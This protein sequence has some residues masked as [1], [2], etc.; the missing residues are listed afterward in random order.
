MAIRRRSRRV[1]EVASVMPLAARHTGFGESLP[2]GDTVY[3]V[4]FHH[5][6]IID[7]M[8]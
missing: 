2:V 7:R 6:A 4:P 5:E 3:V 8:R 1:I